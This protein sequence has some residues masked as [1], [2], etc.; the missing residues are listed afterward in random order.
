MKDYRVSAPYGGPNLRIRRLGDKK[1]S[2]GARREREAPGYLEKI[3]KLPCC[4]PGCD[5][6]P[7]SHAHHLKCTGERGIGKKSSNKWAAPLC[8]ECH[9]NGVERI[10]SRQ[11][12]T[13]FRERG[14]LCLDLAVALYA[15]SH[16]LDA[17]LDVL[18]THREK[19]ADMISDP[20]S[21]PGNAC[22]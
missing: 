8:Y 4:I 9:I 17:M 14:I 19:A 18:K 20:S 12:T 21:E 10:G 16:N 2:A 5:E 13:W 11:E 1:L 22:L 15:N 7:P 3:R 6:P